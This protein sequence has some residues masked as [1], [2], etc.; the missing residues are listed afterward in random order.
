M[1]FSNNSNFILV[2]FFVWLLMA[3]RLGSKQYSEMFLAYMVALLACLIGTSEIMM[4]KPAAFFFTVGGAIAF[5]YI[6]VQATIRVSIR[7]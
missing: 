5:C 6:V 2:G 1:D 7:K 3:P 4:V